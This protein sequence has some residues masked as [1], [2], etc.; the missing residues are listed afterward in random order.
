MFRLIEK[1]TLPFHKELAPEE[2][3]AGDIVK[4]EQFDVIITEVEN[5]GFFVSL[6]D[7]SETT[8]EWK[9]R[10]VS[11]RIPDELE[12]WIFLALSRGDP[13]VC[14][15]IEKQCWKCK[16]FGFAVA[17]ETG[18]HLITE[19]ESVFRYGGIRRQL[20]EFFAD[21][22]DVRAR[23]GRV[24]RRY[25][26]TVTQKTLSQGCPDCDSLWGEFHLTELFTDY[27]ANQDESLNAGIMIF[28][29]EV[30]LER[31]F[32]EGEIPARNNVA[33]DSGRV[34]NANHQ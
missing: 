14:Y 11:R 15:A 4:L 12:Y 34:Q 23:F 20:R 9:P 10:F 24:H 8:L 29:F 33:A 22:P 31:L 1:L 3:Q 25:S 2:I 16:G 28:A 19:G 13:I 6:E 5:D 32:D 26:K 18:G 21:R 17:L 7:G 27:F 30:D